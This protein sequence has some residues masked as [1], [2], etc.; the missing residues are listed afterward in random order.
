MFAH[1]T[2]VVL[3]GTSQHLNVDLVTAW[4]RILH[5]SFRDVGWDCTVVTEKAVDGAMK[6]PNLDFF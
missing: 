1:L 4:L 3:R 2:V 6:A 5:I